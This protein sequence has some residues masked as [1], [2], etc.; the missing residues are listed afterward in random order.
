[1]RSIFDSCNCCC[2]YLL[3]QKEQ[4]IFVVALFVAIVVGNMAVILS[5]VTSK[6]GKRSRM[7]YFIM[8]LAIAG[9]FY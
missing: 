1:M 9:Q 5:I 4:L 6:S 8:H 7:K 3:A 2:F